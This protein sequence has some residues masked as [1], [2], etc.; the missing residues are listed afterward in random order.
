MLSH[1][2]GRDR[3]GVSEA[4]RRVA[5]RTLVVA[6]DSD[7]LFFPEQSWQIAA[8]VPGAY[9]REIHSEHG[10][11]GFLIESDQMS[12]FLDEFLN[13]RIPARASVFAP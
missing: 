10:H 7:R 3:G 8:G 5:A 12:R 13:Q 1:D 2:I 9:Y 4:L 11:D 6:V